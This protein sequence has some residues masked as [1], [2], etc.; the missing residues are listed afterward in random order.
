MNIFAAIGR[1]FLTFLGDTGRLAVFTADAVIGVVRPPVYWALIVQQM[2]RIGYFSLPVVGLTAFFTGGVLAL[3]IYIGGTRFNAESRRAA[4]RGA[5]H[6]PRARPGP[7]RPDGRR[8]RR[9]RH[10][11][12]A[13]HHARHRADRRADD[14]VDQSVQLSGRAR[15][16]SRR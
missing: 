2:M 13:R 12:R 6:H 3:Q 7:R 9:R 14:A 8:P 5:R 16:S 4:D 10:R 15:A 1:V 11:R